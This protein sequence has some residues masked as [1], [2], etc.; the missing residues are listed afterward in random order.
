MGEAAGTGNVVHTAVRYTEA[1]CARSW[2]NYKARF[3]AFQ[4][5]GDEPEE[6][7]QEGLAVISVPGKG[8]AQSR[9]VA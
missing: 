4:G 3:R 1:R 9:A 7:P 6:T 5:R 8:K 2:V